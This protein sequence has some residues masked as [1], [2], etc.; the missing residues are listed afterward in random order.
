[1]ESDAKKHDFTS[2]VEHVQ[3]P[4]Q[5]YILMSKNLDHLTVVITVP[6]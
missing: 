3:R 6:E 4:P 2:P 1:M 5:S